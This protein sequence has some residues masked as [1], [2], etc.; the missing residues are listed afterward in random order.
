ME[1]FGVELS[2]GA[3]PEVETNSENRWLAEAEIQAGQPRDGRPVSATMRRL[4]EAMGSAHE[5]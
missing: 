2:S 3:H 4:H 1:L 5:A